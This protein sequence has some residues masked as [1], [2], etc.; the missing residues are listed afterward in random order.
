MIEHVW[1]VV[2]AKSVID[3]ES[4]NITLM[5]VL[6]QITAEIVI[7]PGTTER[8]S[9][10]PF[11]FELITLWS[12][13]DLESPA[14]GRARIILIS[15]SGQPNDITPEYEIDL[16]I[17]TRFRGRMRSKGLPADT[18]GVARF[19]VQLRIGEEE[20]WHEVASIPIQIDLTVQQ[21]PAA[22]N[23]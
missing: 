14:T 15:P 6:E 4:N 20:E 18:S 21:Q 7:P 2:C 12:R 3:Q 9:V 11:E 19:R 17:H 16:T 5:N 22:D 10:L 23:N 1:T 8:P 13:A